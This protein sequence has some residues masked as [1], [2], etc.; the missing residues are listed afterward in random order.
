MGLSSVKRNVLHPVYTGGYTE[1]DR[2]KTN[3]TAYFLS[4][5]NFKKKKM[6]A[7]G[8]GASL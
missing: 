6:E 5:V 2:K 1:V 3:Q 7:G 8:G 4:K